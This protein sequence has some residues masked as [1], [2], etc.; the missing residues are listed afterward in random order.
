[1]P[2]LFG[3]VPG[4]SYSRLEEYYETIEFAKTYN[5]HEND[6]FL[7]RKIDNDKFVSCSRDSAKL[8]QKST[9]KCI[10]YI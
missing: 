1:M 4:I 9:G 6:V 10:M 7:I 2:E 5:S 8:W 3:K